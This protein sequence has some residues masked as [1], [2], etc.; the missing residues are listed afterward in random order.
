[1]TV[2]C[3]VVAIDAENSC[4]HDRPVQLITETAG[5]IS[6]SALVH[7]GRRCVWQVSVGRGQRVRLRPDVFRP[8]TKSQVLG[9]SPGNM[10]ELP[11]N[12]AVVVI[13]SSLE[14]PP[15]AYFTI[16]IVMS[17]E[18]VDLHICICIPTSHC[19]Y[20]CTHRLRAAAALL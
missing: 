14:S 13:G 19:L 20:L 16:F 15:L 5:L 2:A 17:S 10:T 18:V 1:M 8:G 12:V 9:D 7:S 4:Q 11:K 3:R 6:G